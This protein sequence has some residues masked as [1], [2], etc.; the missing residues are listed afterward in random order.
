MYGWFFV[1]WMW[2]LDNPKNDDGSLSL[3]F[4]EDATDIMDGEE[5]KYW[6]QQMYSVR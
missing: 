1:V 4:A 5:K 6:E 3:V 2:N